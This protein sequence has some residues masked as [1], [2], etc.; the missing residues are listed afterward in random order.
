MMPVF[1]LLPN[2]FAQTA[3]VGDCLP[4]LYSSSVFCFFAVP[5]PSSAELSKM[6]QCSWGIGMCGL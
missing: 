4:F 5:Q 6:S 3:V 1:A 2:L